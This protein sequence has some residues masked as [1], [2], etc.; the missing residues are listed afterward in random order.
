MAA[1]PVANTRVKNIPE[2]QTE[3]IR[4]DVTD[5]ALAQM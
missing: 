3:S 4:A 5:F 2:V 1:C